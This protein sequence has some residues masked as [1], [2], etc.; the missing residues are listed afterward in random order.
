[1]K[2]N[3]HYRLIIHNVE[4]PRS[5][6]VLEDTPTPDP[7]KGKAQQPFPDMKSLFAGNLP[8][9]ATEDTIR[10]LLSPFGHISSVFVIHKPLPRKATASRTMS[11]LTLA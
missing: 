9:D 4:D 11:K 1:M 2:N 8:N 10:Q 3:D 5:R 7:C 6:A